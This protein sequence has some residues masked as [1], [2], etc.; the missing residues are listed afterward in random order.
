MSASSHNRSASQRRNLGIARPPDVVIVLVVLGAAALLGYFVGTG[1]DAWLYP[2]LAVVI[3]GLG[4][5]LI[6]RSYVGLAFVAASLVLVDV[7]PDVPFINSIVTTIGGATVV[8]YLLH[9]RWKS[10][11]PVDELR[12]GIKLDKLLVVALWML[13]WVLISVATHANP[14]G[15]PYSTALTFVQLFVLLWLV[16]RIFENEDDQFLFFL[17]FAILV[18]ISAFSA[19][20]E[21]ATPVTTGIIRASGLA[22]GANK[23]TRYF[24]VDFVI[25]L[26]LFLQR[27]KHHLPKWVTPVLI[28]AMIVNI[29]GV[30]ATASRSG[31]ALLAVATIVFLVLT[32]FAQRKRKVSPQAIA[33]IVAAVCVIGL[34][35]A[36]LLPSELVNNLDTRISRTEE[37][38]DT[39]TTNVRLG[40]WRAGFDMW[41]DHPFDGVG[42]GL[43]SRFLPQYGAAYVPTHYLIYGAH[44]S[45]V[46]ML[47]ETGLIGFVLFIAMHVVALRWYWRALRGEDEQLAAYTALWLTILVVIMIGGITKQDNYERLLWLALGAS[48]YFK[49]RTKPRVLAEPALPEL[50]QASQKA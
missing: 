26:F 18:T 3:I 16:G 40:F 37:T 45:Y 23:A 8:A 20:T 15:T 36:V 12:K 25:L 24:T 28:V 43:F 10:S 48:Y 2:L 4:I 47:S 38:D 42:V 33:G 14:T 11:V 39:I 41:V 32:L 1:S 13:I 30:I 50:E 49:M 7:L 35:S 9:G 19:I 31:L 34:A 17:I 46:A 22:G 44:N 27:G 6:Q 5:V 21:V 29:G